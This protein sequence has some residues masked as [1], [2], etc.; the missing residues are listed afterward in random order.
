MGKKIKT[1]TRDNTTILL[2]YYTTILLYYIKMRILAQAALLTLIMSF[3]FN[4]TR[5]P[6]VPFFA[7]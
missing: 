5:S 1:K 4:E 7:F 6:T 3:Y 2:Y